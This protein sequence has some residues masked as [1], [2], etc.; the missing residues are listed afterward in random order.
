MLAPA[1]E[2]V[3]QVGGAR[4][5]VVLVLVV[6]ELRVPARPF[7]TS[8]NH[9]EYYPAG[10]MQHSTQHAY[11]AFTQRIMRLWNTRMWLNAKF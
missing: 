2:T 7:A 5:G 4:A 1:V 6:G 10:D 8:E 9:R 11:C 3:R